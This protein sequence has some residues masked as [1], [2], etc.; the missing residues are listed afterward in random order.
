MALVPTGSPAPRCIEDHVTWGCPWAEVTEPR[1]GA[2]N[3][4]W[5]K[6]IDSNVSELT[7]CRTFTSTRKKS[8]PSS[9]CEKS[10]TVKV[11]LKR[12]ELK[13]NGIV[14]TPYVL[15]LLLAA[16]MGGHFF[17]ERMCVPEGG[18]NTDLCSCVNEKTSPR[19][20]IPGVEEAVFLAGRSCH[21][22]GISQMRAG[23]LASAGP[24]APPLMVVA[25]LVLAGAVRGRRHSRSFREGWDHPYDMPRHSRHLLF[26]LPQHVCTGCQPSGSV[27]SS[28]TRSRRMSSGIC[29]RKTCSKRWQVLR[30]SIRANI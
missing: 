24:V 7:R 23:W 28:S 18:Q 30:P 26:G 11:H 19:M 14:W 29:S 2:V 17:L 21:H 13:L 3:S 10:A 25:P 4:A 9:G 1:W 6:A 8:A 22:R 5:C 27:K 20:T 15:M 12:Q 16:V